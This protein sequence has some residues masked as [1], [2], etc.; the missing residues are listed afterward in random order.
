FSIAIGSAGANPVIMSGLPPNGV[1]GTAYSHTYIA[2]GT[3][4]ITFSLTSGTLP[5]GLTLSSAGLLSG[6]PTTTGTFTG[7]VTATNGVAPDATQPFSIQITTSGDG[8]DPAP[9]VPTAADHARAQAPLCADASGKTSMIIR[10]DVPP[11]AITGGSVFCRVLAQDGEFKANAAE[12]GEQA[13][14]DMG[15]IQAVDVFGLMHNGSPELRF[16]LPI[17]VCLQG[18]GRFL[19]LDATTSPRAANQLPVSL[20]GEYTCATVFNA[21]L[22]VLVSG[23]PE[24]GITA[25]GGVG[26]SLNECMVTTNHIMNLRVGP[27]ANS[28][29]I[30]LV[31]YNVTLTA[32]QRDG[33]W[34]NVDYLGTA[35]WINAAY[36]KPQGLCGS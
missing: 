17:K 34:F 8:T 5:P 7:V 9:Y 12:I 13:V 15:V 31:P 18:S 32:V 1:K 21:G 36:V 2:S 28:E 35:G 20:E 22:V 6:T 33:E 11:G 26:T 24:A 30:M 4:P 23:T 27:N 19:Y 3:T 16:N 29:V 10:V 25:P 14:L